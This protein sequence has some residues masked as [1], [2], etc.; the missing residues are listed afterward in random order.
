MTPLVL[1]A[2]R[3]TY[4]AAEVQKLFTYLPF[5]SFRQ[6]VHSISTKSRTSHHSE[7]RSGRPPS[8]NH[9]HV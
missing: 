4:A 9:G 8:G 1:L 7:E 5:R 3:L 6:Y 2:K